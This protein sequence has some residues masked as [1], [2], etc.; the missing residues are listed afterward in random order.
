MQLRHCHAYLYLHGFASGPRSRKAVYFS[1]RFQSQGLELVLPD[2]NQDDF[3]HLTLTRQ[4]QQVEKILCN[5]PGPFTLIGSSFGGLTAAWVAQR[6]VQVQQLILLAPAFRFL[7]NWLPQ[8]GVTHIQQW[9]SHGELAIYH[10]AF[11]KRLPLS[12]DFVQDLSGYRDEELNRPVPTLILHG[13]QDQ[14]IPIASSRQYA[15]SRSWVSL[16]ELA[17]DHSLT[18]V[19]PQLWSAIWPLI[20]AEVIQ[21]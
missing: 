10:Y 2:L 4:I 19:L 20:S 11:E 3:W 14:T 13:K 7:E 1:D 21:S 16:T 17:S 18:G 6:Q 8:L 9:Q 12:Y 15:S 5:T